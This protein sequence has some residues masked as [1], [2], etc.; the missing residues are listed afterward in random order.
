LIIIP[1]IRDNVSL[2]FIFVLYGFFG[3]LFIVPLNALIQYY[4]K[5]GEVGTILAAN[6]FVQN[7]F[8]ILFLGASIGLAYAEISNQS[9]FYILAIVTFFGTLYAI[10]KLPQSFIRYIITGMLRRR[11]QVQVVDM[12]NLP[13]SGGV[14]LLGNHVSWLDWAMLQLLHPPDSLCDVS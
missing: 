9:T 12:K 5:E 11:Y 6:N 3:G 10:L 13:S 7:L 1:F 2:S 4:A 14:L 8:M